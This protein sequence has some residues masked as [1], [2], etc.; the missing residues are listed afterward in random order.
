MK[1]TTIFEG[2]NPQVRNAISHTGS[3]SIRI[4]ETDITFR[5]IKR[6]NP[7]IVTIV[8]WTNEELQ[9]KILELLN[10]I[11]LI[12]S[13][14]EIFGFDITEIIKSSKELNF[15]FLDQILDTNGRIALQKSFDDIIDRI[16]NNPDFDLKERLDALTTFYFLESK[17]RNLQ[18]NR[19]LF[20]SEEKIVMIEIPKAEYDDSN[21]EDILSR[22]LKMLRYGILAEPCYRNWAKTI[23]VIEVDNEENEICK[24]VGKVEN[25]REYNFETAGIVDLANDLNYYFKGNRAEIVVNF[26]KVKELEDSNLGRIFPRKK[27]E[28]GM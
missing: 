28:Y 16:V 14:L 4:V 2:Y 21:D 17:K 15:K 23:A 11:H 9:E 6:G 27:R 26:D 22:F 10:F 13:A 12:D 8:K 20:N 1:P 5:N 24:V 19:N 3:D 7:P 18:V 25:Y